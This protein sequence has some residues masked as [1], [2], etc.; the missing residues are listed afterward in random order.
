MNSCRQAP[1]GAYFIMP[2]AILIALVVFCVGRTSSFGVNSADDAYF[3]S[4]AKNVA[5]GVGYGT[6]A[7]GQGFKPF[8]PEIGT[9]PTVILPVAL[10]IMIF[11]NKWWVPGTVT[12]LLWA[13]TLLFLFLTLRASMVPAAA[14]GLRDA[15]IFFLL[16]IPLV[17]PFHF[18]QWS[19]MLGEVPAA[20]L[21]LLSFA[22][23]GCRNLSAR[24]AGL[25]S[26]LCSL[27]FLTKI[28]TAPAYFVLL[29]AIVIRAL[30]L[31]KLGVRQT[32]RYLLVSLAAFVA[33]L[34]VFEGYKLVMLS[35]LDSYVQHASQ[36]M[37]FIASQGT[38]REPEL[39]MIE[40]FYDRSAVIAERFGVSVLTILLV[41]G[42]AFVLVMRSGHKAAMQVSTLIALTALILTIYFLFVSNGW[43]R[44]FVV[45]L[46][47]WMSLV[48]LSMA[49]VPKKQRIALAL[50][51]LSG[52][53][54]ANAAKL[55]F[56]SHGLE[57][58]LFR[59]SHE[60]S[61]ALEVTDTV[62]ALVETSHEQQILIT[63]W[64][65]ATVD[66]EYYSRNV[67][68][69]EAYTPQLLKQPNHPFK[70]VFNKNFVSLEESGFRELMS[71]C[72][73]PEYESSS[74]VISPSRIRR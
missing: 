52:L 45:A 39:S 57:R 12:T 21:L 73:S 36:K 66:V 22:I 15:A 17:F 8:D 50:V 68:V 69:F 43:P 51:C 13:V 47:L 56:L 72:Q 5:F 59:S 19:Q 4:I 34:F 65:G 1:D 26:L 58:G 48:A 63:R 29:A 7:T 42:G 54:V 74:H 38:T 25:A 62:D 33:P 31:E 3:A 53:L 6:T 37:S 32:V 70:T 44:Y 71:L 9:G 20:M 64:W 41:S 2:L 67:G 11:G 55:P 18:G 14:A 30:V 16:M 23:I 10:A 27:A 61:S 35:N 28:L 40:R 46:I 49:V 24:T 60:L